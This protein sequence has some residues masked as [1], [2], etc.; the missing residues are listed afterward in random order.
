LIVYAYIVTIE[1]FERHYQ[2]ITTSSLSILLDGAP[3]GMFTPSRGL[4]QGAPISPFL[5]ILGVEILSR[6]IERE[7]SLGHQNGKDVLTFCLLMMLL[8][9]LRL[10]QMKLGWF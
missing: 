6:L 3:F 2:L 5:F 1:S 7:E 4:R 8:F 10:M 9:S